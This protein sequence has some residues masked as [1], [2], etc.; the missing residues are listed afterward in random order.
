MVK[1]ILLLIALSTSIFVNAQTDS[2][3]CGEF[4][5]HYDTLMGENLIVIWETP[6]TLKKCSQIDLSI[7][8]EFVKEKTNYE[9][10]FVDMI[11][12]S[13]GVPICFRFKQEIDSRV[14]AK[15]ID[16]LKLLRFKPALKRDKGVGSIYTLKI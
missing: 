6:P 11:I 10:L 8:K 16:K 14:M 12:D 2:L 1:V 4:F 5:T 13:E 9:H 3:K 7:L 15:L